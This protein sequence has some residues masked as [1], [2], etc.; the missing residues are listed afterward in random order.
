M[1]GSA[2]KGCYLVFLGRSLHRYQSSALPSDDQ[3]CLSSEIPYKCLGVPLGSYTRLLYHTPPE[4]Q[5]PVIV[6]DWQSVT[7]CQ[8]M[9][10]RL[11]VYSRRKRMLMAMPMTKTRINRTTI[12]HSPAPT[13]KNMACF[14]LPSFLAI[15]PGRNLLVDAP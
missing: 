10:Y 3:N 2:Y 15:L 14:L 5:V 6:T 9:R 12:T 1:I 4:P 7:D 8:C 13:R 11:H